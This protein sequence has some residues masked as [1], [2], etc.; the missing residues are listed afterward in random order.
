MPKYWWKQISSLGSFPKW[1]QSKRRKREKKERAKVN[2][3]NGQNLS[4]EP[5]R[6]RERERLKVG[7]QWVAHAYAKPPGPIPFTLTENLRPRYTGSG[8]K[9]NVQ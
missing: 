8:K 3:Y 6:K 4:P 5:K 1:V 2:D 7:K 9:L